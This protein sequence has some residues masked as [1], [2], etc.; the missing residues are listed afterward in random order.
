[1]KK[2]AIV[3]LLVSFFGSGI[4]WSAGDKYLTIFIIYMLW[5]VLDKREVN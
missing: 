5:L 2:Y 1:M 3:W 4:P